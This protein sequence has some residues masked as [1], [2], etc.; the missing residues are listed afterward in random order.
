MKRAQNHT[1]EK[2]GQL[3]EL[4]KMALNN[5]GKILFEF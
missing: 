1:L 4:L 3:Q 5:L 2:Q